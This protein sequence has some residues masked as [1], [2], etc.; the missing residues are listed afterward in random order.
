[1]TPDQQRARRYFALYTCTTR[2]RWVLPIGGT[3]ASVY[4]ARWHSTGTFKEEER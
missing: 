1:M 4:T 2:R 3:T